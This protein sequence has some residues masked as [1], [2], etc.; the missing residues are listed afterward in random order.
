MLARTLDD[1]AFGA[2]PAV[3]ERSK[4]LDPCSL[5]IFVV[6]I[7]RLGTNAIKGTR[8]SL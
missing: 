4:E 5:G 1:T 2:V 7:Y 8:R 3:R 6:A